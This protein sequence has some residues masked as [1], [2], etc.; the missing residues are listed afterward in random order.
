MNITRFYQ[1]RKETEF[2]QGLSNDCAEVCEGCRAH[3]VPTGGCRGQ[4]SPSLWAEPLQMAQ[5]TA[6][7]GENGRSD[8]FGRER[9]AL[10]YRLPSSD[11]QLRANEVEVVGNLSKFRNVGS[12]AWAEEHFC[13]N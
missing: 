3:E 5:N 9:R 13:L 8:D 7:H 4:N 10:S 12:S 2:C 1:K 6:G 11:R